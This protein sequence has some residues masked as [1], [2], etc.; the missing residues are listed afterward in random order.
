MSGGHG[1]VEG[2]NKKIALLISVLALFLALGETLAKSAQTDAL[3][4]NVEA[5]NLW[6]FFQARTIR[7]T[8]LKTAVEQTAIEAPGAPSEA[9]RKQV[10]EWQKTLGRY[11]SE[12]STGEGRKELAARAKTAEAKRD[13]ALARY[14]HYEIGS[15]AF[16]IGIVLASA[17]VITGITALAIGGG[18]LGVAGIGMLAV[19]LFAPHAFHLF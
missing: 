17:Q 18:L 7:S 2:S 16:Q 8:F 15:A 5:S 11:E 10:E 4:A 13:L 12:P 3:S 6:A 14:H 1:S 19:G 9:V